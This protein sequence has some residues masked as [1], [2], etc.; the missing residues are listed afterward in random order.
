M[1]PST[2]LLIS[3]PEPCSQPWEEMAASANGRFCTHC[4]KTVVD[5]TGMSDAALLNYIKKNGMGCGRFSDSQLER[6]IVPAVS[7]KRKFW[8][9]LFLS[10]GLF[11]GILKESA[12]QETNTD[13]TVIRMETVAASSDSLSKE[14]KAITGITIEGAV[15]DLRGDLVPSA[16]VSVYDTNNKQIGGTVTNFDGNYRV[17]F[18]IDEIE[19]QRIVIVEVVYLGIRSRQTITPYG[20]RNEVNFKL[21]IEPKGRT[22]SG[23]VVIG[24]KSGRPSLVNPKEPTRRTI[25]MN[26]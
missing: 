1:K 4:S 12:G 3:I 2:S 16:G 11:F 8:P 17:V 20:Y 7:P 25:I 19:R 5:F 26:R 13:H 18:P 15:V 14:P 21:D 10:L 9:Q 24:T 22:T 6:V 23:I